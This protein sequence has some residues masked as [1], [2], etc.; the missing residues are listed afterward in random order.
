[1]MAVVYIQTC[2]VFVLET[3]CRAQDAQMPKH[4]TTILWLQSRTSHVSSMMLVEFVETTR[5]VLDA[6]TT[7][8]AIT[9]RWRFLRDNT[10][11]YGSEDLTVLVQTDNW[12]SEFVWSLKDGGGNVVYAGGPY[13][14]PASDFVETLCFPPGCY[15]GVQSLIHS[16]MGFVV[17]LTSEMVPSHS[18]R[19]AW[20]SDEPTTLAILKSSRYA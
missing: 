6:R 15:T 9:I 2:A 18:P 17:I 13:L 14:Y 19:M 12:P 10:C 11:L 8:P 4:A 20:S 5:R 7:W 1:M 16:V 3:T